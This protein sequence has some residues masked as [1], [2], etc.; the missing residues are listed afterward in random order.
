[1]IPNLP[2]LSPVVSPR[3]FSRPAK[4]LEEDDPD[5]TQ[6]KNANHSLD[7][8]TLNCPGSDNV[9]THLLREQ[10]AKNIQFHSHISLPEGCFRL[11]IV[12]PPVAGE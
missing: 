6:G 9:E 7:D 11:T 12:H 8:G 1:M 2:S 4:E 5:K 3:A 10:Q